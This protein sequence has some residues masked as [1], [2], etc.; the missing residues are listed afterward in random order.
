MSS[1]MPLR[2]I[3]GL[4]RAVLRL[5]GSKNIGSQ[6]LRALAVAFGSLLLLNARSL[7]LIWHIRMF[8]H[9]IKWHVL[10]ILA[11]NKEHYLEQVS[12]VAQ[13]PFQ[14]QVSHCY[15]ATPDDCDFLGHLSNSAYAKNLDI[16]R[17]K[18][19][20]HHLHPFM[21]AGGF[22]PMAGADYAYISEIPMFAH[23]EVIAKTASWDD[24]WIY[25]YSEFITRPK[26]TK[27]GKP[28]RGLR[29]DGTKVHCVA[30]SRYVFKLGRIT[31]P[32]RVALSICG[33]G[34]DRRNWDEAVVM[35]KKG[36]LKEFLKGGW[37]D[38]KGLDLPEF[39]ER[40]LAGLEWCQKLNEGMGQAATHEWL[41]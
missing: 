18:V 23:Y 26:Q 36:T 21:L 40:R 35:R 1:R 41:S 34:A 6:Y 38:A 7:P 31:V 5:L 20:V 19:L 16:A 11:P 8:R 14:S 29:P 27:G 2:L 13:D 22:L 33:F 9:L 28:I 37:K 32:P 3:L 25:L 17:M 4:P 39:E 24:K 10:R 15:W 30:I 12:P